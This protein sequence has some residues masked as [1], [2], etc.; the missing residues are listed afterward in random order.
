MNIA[1][2]GDPERSNSELLS[3]EDRRDEAPDDFLESELT[4]GSEGDV[5]LSSSFDSDGSSSF[6]FSFSVSFELIEISDVSSFDSVASF[7]ENSFFFFF[8]FE[9]IIFSEIFSLE[10]LGSC[11]FDPIFVGW[12]GDVG[13]T[14]VEDEFSFSP[15]LF[16]CFGEGSG[17]FL[18]G[19]GDWVFGD[20]IGILTEEQITVTFGIISCDFDSST[21]ELS[22]LPKKF[23][24]TCLIGFSKDSEL[25]ADPRDCLVFRRTE[26]V[27]DDL[28]SASLFLVDFP[29]FVGKP[30]EFLF[31]NESPDEV[32]NVGR[33]GSESMSPERGPSAHNDFPGFP[34]KK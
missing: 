18:F 22:P 5:T 24:D 32:L 12:S 21:E 1:E 7:S 9:A 15:S 31:F 10:P 11:S 13:E 16:E 17:L 14:T 6:D 33:F 29:C 23:C 2:E 30:R 25:L 4:R 20:P 34:F 19:A 27:S 8:N 3:L 26:S 28:F